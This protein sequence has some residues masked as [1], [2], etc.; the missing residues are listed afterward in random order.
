MPPLPARDPRTRPR[1]LL[2]RCITHRPQ[3]LQGSRRG[4][5]VASAKWQLLPGGRNPRTQHNAAGVVGG[6]A[7]RVD[8][9]CV[10][11]GGAGTR[12]QPW[13]QPPPGVASVAASPRWSQGPERPGPWHLCAEACR[14]RTGQEVAMGLG[15]LWRLH[16]V[17][18]GTRWCWYQTMARPTRVSAGVCYGLKRHRLVLVKCAPFSC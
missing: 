10:H 16:H 17:Y 14:T 7:P 5:G 18:N 4:L 6:A 12:E 2:H 11:G 15:S 3:P 8:S 13:S 1:C 9:T